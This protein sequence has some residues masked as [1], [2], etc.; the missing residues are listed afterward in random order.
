ML[1]IKEGAATIQAPDKGPERGPASSEMP[2][3]YNPAMGL[4]R[5]LCVLAVKR[6]GASLTRPLRAVDGLSGTGVRAIRLALETGC[7]FEALVAND[8]SLGA[9]ELI[10]E[11]VLRNNAGGTVSVLRSDL[12]ALLAQERFDYIDIDPFGSPAEFITS[13]VRAVRHNGMLGI[14][15]TD[16]GPLCGTNPSTCFRRYGAVSLRSEHMHETAARILVGFCV[17]T[18]AVQDV[19]LRPVLVQSDDHYIRIYLRAQR[20]IPR[21]NQ[22]LADLGYLAP[23]RTPLS[24]EEGSPVRGKT[25]GPLWLGELFDPEFL[26]GAFSDFGGRTAG[27]ARGQAAPFARPRPL[28]RMLEQMREEA[29]LPSFFFELNTVA[30]ELRAGPPPMAALIEALREAGFRASRTHFSPTGF[31][32]DAPAEDLARLFRAAAE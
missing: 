1:E 20:S 6:L 7:R 9:F 30:Q 8:R 23:G 18:G 25:A 26:E 17:R 2:V 27:W 12:N 11:N 4:V 21:T 14:T 31:R 32:T 10:Q 22:A 28:A 5:D 16:T 15:A 19:A 29:A 24:M 3:F 13:A